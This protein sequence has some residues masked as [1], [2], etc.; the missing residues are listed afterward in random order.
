MFPCSV[1]FFFLLLFYHAMVFFSLCSVQIYNLYLFLPTSSYLFSCL[2]W[3]TVFS[4]VLACPVNIRSVSLSSP[5]VSISRSC[6]FCPLLPCQY[7]VPVS[8]VLSYRVS[9]PS[10]SVL[11]SPTVAI[12]R[13]CQSCP[14][15]PCQ[16]P[17]PVSPVLS[18]RVSIPFLSVLSSPTVSISRPCQSCPCMQKSCPLS[19][20][21]LLLA[22]KIV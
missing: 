16:Y 18:Y 6:Q 7:P 19:V 10:L 21:N 8:P 5:T 2:R 15:L 20:E 12:S 4:P 1:L 22:H 3:P 17:V 11:S 13:P 14:L 9:I